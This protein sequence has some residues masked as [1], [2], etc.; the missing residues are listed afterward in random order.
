MGD[1]EHAA[2][3]RAV[4]VAAAFMAAVAALTM[5]LCGCAAETDE[6]RT[7]E[8]RATYPCPLDAHTY[9][10]P[11]WW[12]ACKEV[13]EV[14]DPRTNQRWWVL[15]INNGKAYGVDMDQYV[16]LPVEPARSEQ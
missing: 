2:F 3:A 4:V 9:D 10:A 6:V 12:P 7:E 5:L 14:C 8:T 16:V 15:R 13:K 1:R 11:A